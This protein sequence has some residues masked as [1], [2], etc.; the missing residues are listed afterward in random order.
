MNANERKVFLRERSSTATPRVEENLKTRHSRVGGIESHGAIRRSSPSVARVRRMDAPNY[1]CWARP[2]RMGPR[3]RGDDEINLIS[4]D[5]TQKSSH[6]QRLSLAPQLVPASNGRRPRSSVATA[7]RWRLIAPHFRSLRLLALP[8]LCLP[9]TLRAQAP[10]A[11]PLS[12]LR[13]LHLPE[14]PGWWPPAPG[15]YLLLFALLILIAG[16]AWLWHRG[17]AQ[18]RLRRAVRAEMSALERQ[19][20][21]GDDAEYLAR[22]SALLRRLALQLH[23]PRCAG[24][25]LSL[26]HI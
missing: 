12:Q 4:A 16:G 2:G 23:G 6:R 9:A 19:I 7:S 8:A 15:W 3:L 17:R 11:D 13:D 18:R 5:G 25:H 22:C 14:Q 24:L 21:Q 1:P 10:A 20:G 26:I